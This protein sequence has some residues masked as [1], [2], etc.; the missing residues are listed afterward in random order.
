L[1]KT[2]K[3]T[4]S[5]RQP[6]T[7]TPAQCSCLYP[8]TIGLPT[9]WIDGAACTPDPQICLQP[10]LRALPAG[11][12]VPSRV[13][14]S[15]EPS[16][17]RGRGCQTLLMRCGLMAGNGGRRPSSRLPGAGV[18]APASP[19]AGGKGRAGPGGDAP[20]APPSIKQRALGCG[21]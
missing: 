4:K 15:A 20:S 2:S 1:E 13:V 9:A 8:E 21:K 12:P 3:L 5:N 7:T 14:P 17:R 18:S 16:G 10:H 11:I 6:N 19:V